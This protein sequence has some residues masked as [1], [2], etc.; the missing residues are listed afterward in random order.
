MP[1]R[2][3]GLKMAQASILVNEFTL[4]RFTLIR[5]TLIRFTLIRSPY[6]CN[7]FDLSGRSNAVPQD[8]CPPP[9]TEAARSA[10]QCRFHAKPYCG[11]PGG[12]VL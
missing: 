7:E 4:I 2:V 9:D 1:D 10:A 6:L 8:T 5:F 12:P 3:S 11:S